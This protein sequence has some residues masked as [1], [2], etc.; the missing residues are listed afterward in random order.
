MDEKIKTWPFRFRAKENPNMEKALFDWPI[1]CSM[2]S[3]RSMG[4]FLESYRAYTHL[5]SFDKPNRYISVR[6]LFLFCSRVFISRS[7]ENRS[8]I[9]LLFSLSLCLCRLYSHWERNK[10]RHKQ[11][12]NFTRSENHLLP[13]FWNRYFAPTRVTPKLFASALAYIKCS[14]F[15]IWTLRVKFWRIKFSS[16]IIFVPLLR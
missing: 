10:D 8:I 9:T 15:R 6:L 1:L 11:Q 5:Y 3:K 13:P 16:S 4:W 2:M 7:Y 14:F 12:Q